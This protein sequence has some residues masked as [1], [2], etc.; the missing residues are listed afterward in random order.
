MTAL[1]PV[2]ALVTACGPELAGVNGAAR[3]FL[4]IGFVCAI[5]LV[6]TGRGREL[7]ILVP[8]VIAVTTLLAVL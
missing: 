6:I 5:G 4:T 8:A 3:G 2:A 1:S 7:M